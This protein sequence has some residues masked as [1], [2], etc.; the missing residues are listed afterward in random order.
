MTHAHVAHTAHA[1]T[2]AAVLSVS[3]R[4][5]TGGPGDGDGDGR[6]RLAEQ[7]LGWTLAVLVAVL[8]TRLGLA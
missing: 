3:R 2:A 5:R 7:V 1:R 4:A 8:A 6:E